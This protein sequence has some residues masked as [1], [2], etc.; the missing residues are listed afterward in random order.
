LTNPAQK[1]A[2]Q[3]KKLEIIEPTNIKL[4]R[5]EVYV[6]YNQ[7][8][9]TATWEGYKLAATILPENVTSKK[10]IWES[11]DPTV[12]EVSNDGYL[13]PKRLGSAV[14]TA[15]AQANGIKA[16][17][18]VH[19]QRCNQ[20]FG[21]TINN[22]NNQGYLAVQNDW[23]YFANPSDSMGLYKMKLDGS[24]KQKLIKNANFPTAYINVIGNQIYYLANEGWV[25]RV[26]IYGE[27]FEVLNPTLPAIYVLAIPGRVFHLSQR[28]NAGYGVYYID[29]E[30]MNRNVFD[31]NVQ[32]GVWRLAGLN[33][34][35]V[36]A[37][38]RGDIYFI[39]K[40]NDTQWSE[41]D[42]IYPEAQKNF[43]L[44][45]I[46]PGE[47]LGGGAY[48]QYVYLIESKL[49]AIV[50]AG[51]I[52]DKAGRKNEVLFRSQVQ[53][54]IEGL[55]ES[56]GWLFYATQGVLSKIKKDGTQNQ[57]IDAN[58][59]TGQHF[60]FP[61]RTGNSPNDLWIYVYTKN[62]NKKFSLFKIRHNG[63]EKTNL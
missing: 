61:V 7:G 4:N 62:A 19:V 35:F 48:P 63:M 53:Q 1:K 15:T 17:C 9:M 2:D 43:V 20:P 52:M 12:V 22:L 46:S 26:D 51:P 8:L 32:K 33:T 42:K 37:D 36:F 41:P 40:I 45:T 5:S 25:H 13:K 14:V 59:P 38:G 3:F 23:I 55:T 54:P 44:E 49:N 24:E 6:F 30:G 58:L 56:E 34:W 29:I 11:S 31:W 10:I 57:I 47:S 21:N 60:L 28:P 18:Q 27:N 50:K 39:R 16:Q